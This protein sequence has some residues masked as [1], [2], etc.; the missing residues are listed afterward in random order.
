M[1]YLGPRGNFSILHEVPLPR[2]F[3]SSNS[4][5]LLS[6]RQEKQFSSC[7]STG[8][9]LHGKD[10]TG[11]K[12]QAHLQEEKAGICLIMW[13]PLPFLVISLHFFVLPLLT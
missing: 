2:S 3:P 4:L 11:G 5:A 13:V 9:C 12:Q 7:N 6:P 8:K 1:L 10:D